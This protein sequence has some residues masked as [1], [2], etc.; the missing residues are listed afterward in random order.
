MGA[1]IALACAAILTLY[2]LGNIYRLTQKIAK[3]K[4]SGLP[5][6][7]LPVH[8]YDTFWLASYWIWASLLDRVLPAKWKGIR[9]L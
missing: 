9:Y 1:P 8:V 6:I 5:Y 4:A 2:L 3:A 7:V